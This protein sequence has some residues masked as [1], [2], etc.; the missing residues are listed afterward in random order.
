MSR[1][2]L[3]KMIVVFNAL[4]LLKDMFSRTPPGTHRLSSPSLLLLQWKRGRAPGGNPVPRQRP[5]GADSEADPADPA[6]PL[7]AAAAAA[8]DEYEEISLS[9][10]DMP[11]TQ[12]RKKAAP[13]APGPLP[14]PLLSQSTAC[15]AAPTVALLLA[16]HL[17]PGP[18]LASRPSGR[19]ANVCRSLSGSVQV[20]RPHQEPLLQQHGALRTIGSSAPGRELGTCRQKPQCGSRHWAMDVFRTS[21]F[22]APQ[23]P[24]RS[25][26]PCS[27][28][29]LALQGRRVAAVAG[30]GIGS[31][32]GWACTSA[33]SSG[34][35]CAS[36]RI[37]AI[38]SAGSR[39][40]EFW[41]DA[42][43]RS[44]YKIAPCQLRFASLCL[45]P[46]RALASLVS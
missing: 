33:S 15:S 25:T 22:A 30:A 2:C 4:K 6:A 42:L 44:K 11:S 13:V 16:M 28:A 7:P 3:G 19:R 12:P 35:C 8:A 39:R 36:A 38:A 23:P 34:S 5:G 46:G 45:R 40:R 32:G 21:V 41:C 31:G 27:L 14:L 20:C 43:G 17:P 9:A 29:W 18:G 26:Q 10:G 37:A 1:A 24:P